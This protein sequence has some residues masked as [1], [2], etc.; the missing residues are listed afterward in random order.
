MIK[1]LQEKCDR[2]E[3]EKRDL[4]NRYIAATNGEDK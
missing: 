4:T 1:T 3:E 2:L